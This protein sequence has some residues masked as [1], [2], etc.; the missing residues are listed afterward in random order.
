VRLFTKNKDKRKKEI[1][2]GLHKTKEGFGNKILNLF[3]SKEID[4]EFY[5]ELEELLIDSDVGI[6]TTLHMINKL[7]QDVKEKKIKNHKELIEL[8]KNVLNQIIKEPD[9]DIDENKLNIIFVVGVNGVGKT[10][11]IAKLA[12]L[13]KNNGHIVIIGACDTF[14][15][16]AVEQLTEW[17][18]RIDVP[19]TKKEMGSDP[20][21]VLYQAIDQAKSRNARFLIVDTAGR[22]HNRQNLMKEIEKLNRIIDRK[23]KEIDLRKENMLVIDANTGQ[24]AYKQAE[25]FHKLINIDSIFLA[26]LDSTSKGGIVIPISYNLDIPIEYCGVGEKLDNIIPFDKN[27]YIETIIGD[28]SD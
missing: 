20:G 3:R 22:L 27:E 28:L 11:S 7:K 1:E 14:R 16:A 8:F 4:D 26:K 12:Y 25:D 13:L 18:N 10:T 19:I 21:S 24:N 6:E 17:A 9:F 2:H 23:S 15:A 5:D